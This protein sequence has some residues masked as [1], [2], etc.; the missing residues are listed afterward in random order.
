MF[1]AKYILP[2]IVL[3]VVLFTAPFWLNVGSGKY[4][5]PELALPANGTECVEPREYMAANHKTLLNTWRDMALREER[6]I[7]V[8]SSGKEWEISLQNTCMTCHANSAGFCDKCHVSN[9]V[10]PTC[11]TCH[12]EPRGNR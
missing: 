1:N 2:G 12:I 4:V 7:Y 10:Y 8:S 9:S 5:R 6:R 3:F 11:W